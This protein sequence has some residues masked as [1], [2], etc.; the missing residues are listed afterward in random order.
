MDS[1]TDPKQVVSYEF[2]EHPSLIFLG[3]GKCKASEGSEILQKKLIQERNLSPKQRTIQQ[4]GLPLKNQ[5]VPEACSRG[6]S[7][8]TADMV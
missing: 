7:L 5:D 2:N 6:M 8:L 1:N 3:F 4:C